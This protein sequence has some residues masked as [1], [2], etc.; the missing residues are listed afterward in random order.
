[1]KTVTI[2]TWPE[3]KEKICACMGIEEKYF[4]DYHNLIGGDYKDLWHVA[5]DTYVPRQMA[6]D[7]IVTMYQSE[8]SKEE[9]VGYYKDKEWA[10]PMIEA[11]NK[12][13]RELNP[14]DNGVYVEFSW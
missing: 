9:F 4:R 8:W 1:M 10:W 3:L 5:L 11:Y 12:V 13:M 2:Y 14:D 6:N 7:T